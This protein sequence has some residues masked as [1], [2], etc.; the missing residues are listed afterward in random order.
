MS[1]VLGITV[2]IGPAGGMF[3]PTTR[4][5]SR[6]GSRST[7]DL[8]VVFGVVLG[9]HEIYLLLAITGDRATR[10]GQPTMQFGESQRSERQAEEHPTRRHLV[11][12]AIARGGAAVVGGMQRSPPP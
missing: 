10:L 12:V 7:H 8:T 11:P 1:L 9:V 5:R 4:H 6:A 3:C 2:L